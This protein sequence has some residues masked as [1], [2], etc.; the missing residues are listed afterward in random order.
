MSELSTYTVRESPRAKH[1]RLMLS[2]QDG[3]VVVVP[4]GFDRGR[5]P[6]LLQKKK[7]W[8]ANASQRIEAQ[9]KFSE[10]E[11]PLPE[12]MAL[13]GI[14][15]DWTIEYRQK[16]SSRVTVVERPGYRLLVSG[17]TDN[18]ETCR[19]TLRRWLSRKAH[20]KLKPWLASLAKERGF[21]FGRVIVRSQRTR[22]GSCSRRKNVGLNM[23]LLFMP[24]ALVRQVLIHELC[25]TVH[26][27]RSQKF[28]A[29]LKHH[30]PDCA[31]KE[32]E[33]RSAG[34]F[35]PAW[36]DAKKRRGRDGRSWK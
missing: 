22:W 5:I 18:I 1:V 19:A 16:K 11:P 28:W 36:I 27:N 25:H 8:L 4:M 35:V 31:K 7:R 23:K 15:E 20:V 9:R 30:E 21:Q 13:Q 26:L 29:L 6:N 24:E 33:L 32:K 2:L 3:L 14:G 10:S 17:N 34:R 12:R